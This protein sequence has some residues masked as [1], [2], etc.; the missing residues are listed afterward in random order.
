MRK[1]LNNLRN[2]R[3]IN[4]IVKTSNSFKILVIF[5]LLACGPS[6]QE[7]GEYFSLF[8]PE[9]ANFPEQTKPYFYTPLLLN[10]ESNIYVDSP[11]VSDV[12]PDVKE[13]VASWFD[14]FKGKVG[15]EV[16]NNGLYGEKRSLGFAKS[17]KNLNPEASI[18]LQF[19]H[20]VEKETPIYTFDWEKPESMDTLKLLELNERAKNEFL[21]TKDDFLKERYLFQYVKLSAVNGKH[22]EIL[23]EYPALV[24]QIK[25]KTFISDWSNS[26]L[27]GSK[28]AI[29]DTAQAVFD[30]AQI[31][32]KSVSRRSQADLSVRRL[33]SKFFESAL[34]FCKNDSEKSNVY[35]LNAIQP[36]QDGLTLAK[37]IYSIDAN[38]PMLELVTAREINK[39]EML[40][41][42]EKNSNIYL[43]EPFFLN[44]KFKVDQKQIEAGKKKGES[45]LNE[46]L[47]FTSLVSKDSKVKSKEFWYLSSAYL[48]YL[49]GDDEKANQLLSN[50]QNSNNLYIQK[51]VAFLQFEFSN[52]ALN[53]ENEAALIS[54]LAMFTKVDN[55]RDNNM[56]IKMSET[57][58][59]F[60]TNES[61]E[62]KSWGWFSSCTKPKGNKNGN[63]VKAFL[64]LNIGATK[65]QEYGY[66]VNKNQ[67]FY[68]DT[69]SAGFLNE[70][71]SFVKK[72]SNSKAEKSLISY[73]SLETDYLL[74][75]LGRRQIKEGDYTS[76]LQTFQSI[77]PNY[78]SQI[79]FDDYLEGEP[80]DFKVKNAN[81]NTSVVEYLKELVSLKQKTED[82]IADAEAWF[83][84][85]KSLYNL[86][87]FG[88][89]WILTVRH[90]SEYD[91]QYEE[92]KS[93]DY[94]STDKAKKCF[95]KAL[96]L[97]PEAEL[98]ARICYA[99]ALC[100]RNQYLVKFYANQ[101]EDYEKQ[102]AYTAEMIKNELPKFRSYFNKLWQN[103]RTTQYHKEVLKECLTYS[104]FVQ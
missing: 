90:K 36:F 42:S 13:N 78:L 57:L 75:A 18:Y 30:F 17:M 22:Q 28:M 91:L 61:K 37:K 47:D 34:E 70:V 40:F 29:G 67:D 38:H 79:G 33:N 52:K 95:E 74:L 20:E 44:D 104:E 101:P 2:Y 35:A 53:K 16:I 58:Y 27:A 54:K 81:E 93:S 77:S 48:F 55:F 43:A 99:G 8:Y 68:T 51:Q 82:K 5:I 23:A 62:K 46:I 65:S 21:L 50:L 11:T 1:V 32:S 63:Q 49:N 71:I 96:S 60:Y 9:S 12:S 41:F 10:T 59:K 26:R 64:A 39:N 56:L 3:L 73:S 97:K 98:A 14:Y 88:Q 4:Y 92:N 31:F 45:Y 69:C 100:E 76:A 19:S 66:Q 83:Q 87:Y 89:A 84:Y 102:D 25:N 80:K 85:G 24:T 103:Y 86:S 7:Y 15:K 72:P 6:P 94:Y